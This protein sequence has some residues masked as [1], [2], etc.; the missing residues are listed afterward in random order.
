MGP[1]CGR[2]DPGGPHV[3]P[4]NLATREASTLIMWSSL[5]YRALYKWCIKWMIV[6]CVMRVITISYQS[7]LS[8]CN[9]PYVFVIKFSQISYVVIFTQTWLPMLYHAEN[10]IVFLP[11]AAIGPT[12]IAVGHCVRPSVRLSVCSSVRPERYPRSNVLF[13][14]FSYQPQIWW[15]DA[16]YHGADRYLK[17]PCSAN[18]CASHGTL[19]FPW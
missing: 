2:Q 13:K 15:N 6:C 5:S 14:D 18:F 12:G 1:I 8:W 19:N 9:S 16:Q 11:S 3:G 7:L 17:C 10:E 4:M